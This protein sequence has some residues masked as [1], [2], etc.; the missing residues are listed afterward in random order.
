[1]IVIPNKT[2][3]NFW[4]NKAEETKRNWKKEFEFLSS[5]GFFSR[6]R[7][8]KPHRIMTT[9]SSHLLDWID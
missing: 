5:T 9:K 3:G 7:L 4:L 6:K 2:T 8:K 1:M